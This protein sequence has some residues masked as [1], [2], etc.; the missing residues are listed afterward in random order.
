MTVDEFLLWEEYKRLETVRHYIVACQD[1]PLL[2]LWAR[3]E[4][5]VWSDDYLEGLDAILPLEA[6]GIELPLA[7]IYEGVELAPRSTPGA[8]TAAPG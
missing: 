5:G 7:E 6:L 2:K 1:A 3:G 4:D 8:V